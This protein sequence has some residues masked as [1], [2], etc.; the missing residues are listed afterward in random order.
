MMRRTKPV[1]HATDDV[2]LVQ[3]QGHR[4]F[5]RYWKCDEYQNHDARRLGYCEP[6]LAGLDGDT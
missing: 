6:L 5:S 2:D 3:R 1:F 4:G